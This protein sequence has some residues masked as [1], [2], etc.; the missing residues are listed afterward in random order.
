ME[1]IP[2]GTVKSRNRQGV[3][4]LRKKLSDGDVT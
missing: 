2:L 1:P 3:L 4:T